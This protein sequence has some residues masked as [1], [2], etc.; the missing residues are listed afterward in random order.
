VRVQRPSILSLDLD[1]TLWPV[2]PVIAAAE[3]AVLEWLREHHPSVVE[4]HDVASMRAERARFAARHPE[5]GHNL[6]LVRRRTLA[7]AFLAAGY[8]PIDGEPAPVAEALAVFHH[9]R[10]RVT[11]YPDALPAL[12]ALGAR[13]RLFAISN[14]NADLERCGIARFFEGH[15]T[16]A[17]AGAAKPDARIFQA[18]LALGGVEP[19]DV[20]HVGDDPVTDMVGARNAGMH[21]VWLNRHARPWPDGLDAQPCT[22]ETLV[23]L[24]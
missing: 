23:E 3:H 6:T 13:Y 10:N 15:V 17:A 11:F 24:L 22:I 2:E 14:G 18:L 19:A 5:Y 7:E 8:P 16:A 4:G 9:M 1:D 21:C 12:E 20:V